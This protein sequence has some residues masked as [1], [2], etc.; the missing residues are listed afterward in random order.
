[1]PKFPEPIQLPK[2]VPGARTK[3][4][5]ELVTSATRGVVIRFSI[6]LLELFGVYKFGSSALMMDAI[7]SLVD[8]FSSLFLIFCIKL[9][10]KPPDRNHPFGHGRFEPLAGLFLGFLLVILGIGIFV[11]ECYALSQPVS[12]LPIA[13]Y[14]W[15]IPFGAVILLEM[16]YQLLIRSAKAYHSPAIAA[17]AYH[18]RIDGGTSLIAAIALFLA[19][20]FPALGQQID[21]LGAILIS[22]LMVVI[23]GLASKSNLDQMVDRKPDPIFFKRIR[24]AAQSVTGVKGTEKIRIQQYG[25][26]AHVN[27]DVEVDPKLDV[28]SAHKISQKVRAA[29]QK[30]WPN[31]LDVIVHIEPF[32]PGDHENEI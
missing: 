5:H 3:R 28:E 11:R 8:V 13:P 7:S 17:D 4:Y 25:P 31:V 1:M 9:A 6:I 29:I 20:Y 12:P 32:Y 18:Y 16:C 27:I 26:N 2:S 15:L 24:K 10:E 19:S 23:G 21:T 22:I 30:E 14:L